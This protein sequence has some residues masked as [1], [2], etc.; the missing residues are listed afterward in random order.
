MKAISVSQLNSYVKSLLKSD[1][2]LSQLSIKGEISNFVHHRSGHMYLDL[3]DDSSKIRCVFFKWDNKKMNTTLKDG[4]EIVA[5]GHVDY[6]EKEG[7]LQFYIKNVEIEGSGLLFKKFQELKDKLDKEGLFKET[8]KKQL[9]INPKRIGVIT[10]STGAAIHDIINVAIRRNPGVNLV[11]YPSLVQ[12]NDAPAQLIERLK[13]LD[14]YN[15]DVI[16]IGRGGGSFE[17]L[18]AFNDELLARTVFECQTPIVS[19][20]GHEIDFSIIDFVADKRAAT[21]S[22][23]AEIVVPNINEYF[24]GFEHLKNRM[25]LL[26][27]DRIQKIDHKLN[28]CKNTLALKSPGQQLDNLEYKLASLMAQIRQLTNQKSDFNSLKLKGLEAR[29]K[30][31]NPYEP[32]NKGYAMVLDANKLPLKTL[33]SAKQSDVVYLKMIDGEELITFPGGS[34]EL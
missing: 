3:K 1:M 30:S 23:A 14:D 12:G 33:K 6:Y 10:A 17:D 7:S 9:P 19:A 16:I 28:V 13:Y 29:L 31:T 25:D 22:E 34:D 11:L 32:I 5:T 4:D 2:L 15:V 18:N 24:Q 27:K 21:P 8:L 26:I 20:V